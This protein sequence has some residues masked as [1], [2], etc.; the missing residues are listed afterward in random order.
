[1]I[2]M[3]IA[4]LFDGLQGITA[5]GGSVTLEKEKNGSSV[6]AISSG[7]HLRLVSFS[8]FV[9]ILFVIAAQV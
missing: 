1:M 7:T 8:S 4:N 5:V 3:L 2:D 9:P 6:L